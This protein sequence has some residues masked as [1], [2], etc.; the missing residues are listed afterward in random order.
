MPGTDTFQ[1]LK[2]VLVGCGKQQ[3]KTPTNTLYIHIHKKKLPSSI[4]H[5]VRFPG[6]RCADRKTPVMPQ[7][8]I[9]V[10]QPY[11][12]RTQGMMRGVQ[13]S[14]CT[15]AAILLSI[16]YLSPHLLGLL[17]L[18]GQPLRGLLE[19]VV[20]LCAKLCQRRGLCQ[21]MFGGRLD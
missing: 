9:N 21:L 7:L 2:M 15:H 1:V 18:A 3:A 17:R 19:F 6:K 5:L 13:R 14:A 10:P 4:V 20:D 16:L 8:S 11:G 12:S